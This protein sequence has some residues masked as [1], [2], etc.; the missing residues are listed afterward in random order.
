MYDTKNSTRK[1][2]VHS[3]IKIFMRSTKECK[4]YMLKD[5]Y[6][7]D[8][9]FIKFSENTEE[10][11]VKRKNYPTNRMRNMGKRRAKNYPTR[12]N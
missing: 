4:L 11:R 3:I 10:S 12:Y 1:I 7:V 8:V 6:N 5:K 2:R 9:K